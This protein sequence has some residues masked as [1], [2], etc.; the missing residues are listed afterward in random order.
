MNN[1]NPSEWLSLLQNVSDKAQ[2]FKK[3]T[4]FV[5]R[6]HYIF[7]V[8]SFKIWPNKWCKQPGSVAP[9]KNQEAGTSEWSLQ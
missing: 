6:H 7:D 8:F 3:Q 2:F 4:A 1:T 9:A 5:S